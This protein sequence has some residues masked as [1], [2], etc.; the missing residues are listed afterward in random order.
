M[1]YSALNPPKSSPPS[2]NDDDGGNSM[3]ADD[4]SAEWFGQLAYMSFLL[5][6]DAPPKA[7]HW[8]QLTEHQ[9]SWFRASAQA[10]I[11][12]ADEAALPSR[13]DVQ[14]R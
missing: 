8:K 10:A 1:A 5:G 9:R 4:A 14:E 3:T 7:K 13:D 12:D 2:K 11:A 6:P